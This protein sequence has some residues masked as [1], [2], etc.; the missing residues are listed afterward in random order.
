[1][2]QKPSYSSHC[3]HLALICG[4]RLRVAQCGSAKVCVCVCNA[5]LSPRPELTGTHVCINCQ[6]THEM[7]HFSWSALSIPGTVAMFPV[8]PTQVCRDV[9]LPTLSGNPESRHSCC[10]S[11]AKRKQLHTILRR[12]RGESPAEQNK[13]WQPLVLEKAPFQQFLQETSGQI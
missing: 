8:C 6:G 9:A 2:L 11:Q 12:P 5:T 13:R 3:S 10:Q 1:M 4:V 7:F